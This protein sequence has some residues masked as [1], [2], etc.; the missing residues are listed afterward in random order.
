MYEECGEAIEAGAAL[1]SPNTHLLPL[2]CGGGDL[3]ELSSPSFTSLPPSFPV[4]VIASCPVIAKVTNSLGSNNTVFMGPPSIIL[5]VPVAHCPSRLAH[6]Q[7]TDA[8]VA[9][10]TDPVERSLNLL[11]SWMAYHSWKTLNVLYDRSLDPSTFASF[12]E[13]ISSYYIVR[14]L[15]M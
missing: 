2:P 9:P 8:T 6:R 12:R 3:E 7:A 13:Y 15:S 5:P 1:P 4:V 14:Y 10:V 11:L